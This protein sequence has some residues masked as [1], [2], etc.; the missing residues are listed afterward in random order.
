MV[1]AKATD[2]ELAG[3]ILDATDDPAALTSYKVT[4]AIKAACGGKGVGEA[5]AARLVDLA[6]RRHRSRSVDFHRREEVIMTYLE[7]AAAILNQE[8]T[9]WNQRAI[10]NSENM[11]AEILDARL[12]IAE[13]FARL[14]AIKA[15]LP[16]CY[17]PVRPEPGQDPEGSRNG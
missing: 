14:A 10:K 6:Q 9:A 15:G 16:P 1:P 7:D 4:K 12:R 8:L 3:I 13:G 5:R 17:H 2:D 11:R